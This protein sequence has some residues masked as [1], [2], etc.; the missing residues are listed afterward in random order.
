MERAWEG[1]EQPR[2]FGKCCRAVAEREDGEE[3]VGQNGT[4]KRGG[5]R[6]EKGP[7]AIRNAGRCMATR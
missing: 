7:R 3:E 4:G 2:E 6:T 1:F 5:D